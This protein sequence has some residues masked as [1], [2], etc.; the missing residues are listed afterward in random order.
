MKIFVMGK[1]HSRM[2][3]PVYKLFIPDVDGKVDGL[4][5]LK[6]PHTYNIQSYNLRSDLANYCFKGKKIELIEE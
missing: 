6:E 4:R 5:K 2:G 3:N 1:S